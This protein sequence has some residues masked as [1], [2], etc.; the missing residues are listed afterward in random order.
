MITA[1]GLTRERVYIANVVKCR[2]PGNRTPLADEV[3]TC[4]P[5]LVEQI[6]TI[7]RR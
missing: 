1:M 3:A 6:Q 4:T 7:R 5:Y 2:P